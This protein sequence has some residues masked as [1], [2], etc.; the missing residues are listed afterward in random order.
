MSA[1]GGVGFLAGGISDFIKTIK[2]IH[3]GS[4]LRRDGRIGKVVYMRPYKKG[5]RSVPGP[6]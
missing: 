1:L 5:I 4:A 3:S 2:N 6:L